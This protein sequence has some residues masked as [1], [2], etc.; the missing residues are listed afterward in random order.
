MDAEF[1][2]HLLIQFHVWP[3]SAGRVSSVLYPM[4]FAELL[5]SNISYSVH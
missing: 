2:V 1:R 3:A 4:T 5:S